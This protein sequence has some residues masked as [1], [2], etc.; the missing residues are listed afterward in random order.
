MGG[1]DCYLTALIDENYM[2]NNCTSIIF[3]DLPRLYGL[4]EYIFARL[5]QSDNIN[6]CEEMVWHK[7]IGYS[8]NKT[9][10][11]YGNPLPKYLTDLMDAH[12]SIPKKVYDE[13]KK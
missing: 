7:C 1:I 5:I 3:D 4:N 12:L 9:K 11:T 6:L 13:V 8:M 2:V 10:E